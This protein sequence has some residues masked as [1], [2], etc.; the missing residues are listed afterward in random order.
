MFTFPSSKVLRTSWACNAQPVFRVFFVV[1]LLSFVW[2]FATTWSEAHQ[3]S[4]H[5]LLELAHI[6]IYWVNDATQPSHPL[7][8]PSS[9]AFNFSSIRIFSNES[10]LCIRWPKYWNFSFNI[11]PSN[12]YLGLISF[13]MDWLDLLAVQGLNLDSILKSRDITLPKRSI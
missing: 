5:Q 11:S 8:P 4:L 3:A 13:R 1:Q 6:H 7:S 10:V 12:E 9:P 2:L